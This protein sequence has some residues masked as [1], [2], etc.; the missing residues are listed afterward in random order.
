MTTTPE[1]ANARKPRPTRHRGPVML[2]GGAPD[3]RRQGATTATRVLDRGGP[4]DGV[5]TDR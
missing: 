2:R 4:I 5:Q 1:P 3:P